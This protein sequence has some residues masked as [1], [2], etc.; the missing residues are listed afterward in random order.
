M[1]DQQNQPLS[2]EQVLQDIKSEISTPVEIKEPY[3]I[4][5]IEK[6]RQMQKQFRT[7]PVLGA[8]TGIKKI[9]YQLNHS[10]FSQQ[11]NINDSLL[12]LIEELYSEVHQIQTS[13]NHK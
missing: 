9:F 8:L 4:Q 3:L 6:A 7:T 1:A 13:Q 11:F 5:L 12:K 10:A 2:A